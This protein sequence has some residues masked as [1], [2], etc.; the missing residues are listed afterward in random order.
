MIC[1]RTNKKEK[2]L[3]LKID[4]IEK[5]MGKVY[6]KKIIDGVAKSIIRWKTKEECQHIKNA[7]ILEYQEKIQMKPTEVKGSMESLIGKAMEVEEK[8]KVFQSSVVFYILSKGH[9]MI[10]YP[11]LSSLLHFAK[12]CYYAMSH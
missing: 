3:Q 8:A 6:E 5:H 11:S 1:T 12:F 10:D 2:R 7:E 4:T 9:P